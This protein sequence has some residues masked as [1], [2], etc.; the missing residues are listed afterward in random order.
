M[1]I[2]HGTGIRGGTY[3]YAIY[4]DTTT[5]KMPDMMQSYEILENSERLQA[6]KLKDH[7]IMAIFHK[8]GKLAGFTT[9]SPGIFIIGKRLI[10]AADPTHKKRIFNLTLD[11]KKYKITLPHGA[12]SGSTVCIVK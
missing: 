1:T 8:P 4:P 9:D 3:E 5:E 12:V 11:G 2:D 6:V 10:F 7:T